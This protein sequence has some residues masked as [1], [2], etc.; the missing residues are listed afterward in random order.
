MA[1]GI[2]AGDIELMGTAIL[3]T[4]ET[5][6]DITMAT[7]LITTSTATGHLKSIRKKRKV[8]ETKYWVIINRKQQKKSSRLAGFFL[9]DI[10]EYFQHA[11]RRLF[12]CIQPV[13]QFSI[14]IFF[15]DH[16]FWRWD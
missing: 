16:M 11:L 3:P 4:E 12:F 8:Q 7:T 2:M 15:N 9:S 14:F 13:N 10:S 6:A 5:M 1:T